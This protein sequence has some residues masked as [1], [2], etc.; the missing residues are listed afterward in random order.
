MA[1]FPPTHRCNSLAFPNNVWG[2]PPAAK[3]RLTSATQDA[4]L[5][6]DLM[7][8][9]YMG[10]AYGKMVQLP[11]GRATVIGDESQQDQPL[12]DMPL[13]RRWRVG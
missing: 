2:L 8:S 13:G 9:R 3:K 10:G 11:H 5:R 1:R 7:T 4:K 6:L 12:V